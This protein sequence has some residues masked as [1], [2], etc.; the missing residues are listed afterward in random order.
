[1]EDHRKIAE[2]ICSTYIKTMIT[3]NLKFWKQGTAKDTNPILRYSDRVRALYITHYCT[4]HIPRHSAVQF[5]FSLNH[6]QYSALLTLTYR[7]DN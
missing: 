7:K 1:M 4:V 2:L 5:D 6:S 3:D